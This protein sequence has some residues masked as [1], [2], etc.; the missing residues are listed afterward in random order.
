M[1]L[2][3]ISAFAEVVSLGAVLPFLG[4]L[5]APDLV[6][7]HPMVADM[8]RTWGFSSAGQLV[9]PLTVAFAAAALTAGAIRILLLWTY[10]RLAF[11][12]GA[13]VS[14]EVY[15]RTLY[16]PYRVHVARNSSELISGIINKVHSIVFLVLLPSLALISSVVLLVAIVLVLIAI[17]TSVALVAIIGFGSMYGLISWMFRRQLRRN[18]QRIAREQ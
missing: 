18:S 9:L 3:L 12:T 2:T 6:F 8:V 10:I 15:R 7:N 4:I 17:H 11:A 16:Q 13:D 14:V 5:A 1:G